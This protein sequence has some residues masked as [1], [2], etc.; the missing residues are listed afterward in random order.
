VAPLVSNSI[1]TEASI[2]NALG[3][4]PATLDDV[5]AMAIALG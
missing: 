5:L 3:S 1:V 2:I 4:R